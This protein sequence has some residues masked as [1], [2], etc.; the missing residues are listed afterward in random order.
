VRNREFFDGVVIGLLVSSVLF[1]LV[2]WATSPQFVD[3]KEAALSFMTNAATLT[4]GAI[5]FSVAART[6]EANRRSEKDVRLSKLEAARSSLPL[7]LADI[8]QVSNS[9]VSELCAGIA[10]KEQIDNETFSTLKECIEYSRGT[11]RE[12]LREVMIIY[13]IC[14]S[15]HGT[16]K[17]FDPIF[18]NSDAHEVFNLYRSCIDWA[19]L[20]SVSETLYDYGRGSNDRVVR[21]NAPQWAIRRVEDFIDASPNLR[22]NK[23][24]SEHFKKLKETKAISFAAPEWRSGKS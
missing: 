2:L 3:V 21:E 18:K 1:L 20:A 17:K 8:L 4:A 11:A 19:A 14:Q 16:S 15:R 13:Q 10:P 7:A 22:N 23:F 9:K 6:I 12:T 5:A 24:V